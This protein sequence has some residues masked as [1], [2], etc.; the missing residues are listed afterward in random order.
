MILWIVSVSSIVFKT[1]PSER[2]TDRQRARR[3]G[4]GGREERKEGDMDGFNA[5]GA[6]DGSTE[7]IMSQVRKQNK[8]KTKSDEES[9]DELIQGALVKEGESTGTRARVL[10]V[11]LRRPVEMIPLNFQHPGAASC[12]GR[13]CAC[14]SFETHTFDMFI[15]CTRIKS[16]RWVF[17]SVGDLDFDRGRATDG[18]NRHCRLSIVCYCLL[19]QYVHCAS[20]FSTLPRA[21]TYTHAGEN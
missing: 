12:S 19:V 8:K 6:A 14:S 4:E 15:T 20:P 13:G 10:G 18:R 3:K 11:P 5:G 7:Q 21:R 2:A 17:S 9:M 1:I 16:L